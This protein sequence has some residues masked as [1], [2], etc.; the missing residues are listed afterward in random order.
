MGKYF[1][2]CHTHDQLQSEY[3]HWS[4]RLHPD[5]GGSDADFREMKDEYDRAKCDIDYA[6][7]HCTLPEYFDENT[8]YEYFRRPVKFAGTVCGH[9]YKFEQEFGAD[10]LITQSRINLIFT[11]NKELA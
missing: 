3:R 4:K 8:S 7:V 5:V 9:Y 11:R 2:N 1:A 10:I 6:T